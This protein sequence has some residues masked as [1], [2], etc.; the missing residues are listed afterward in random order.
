MVQGSSKPLSEDGTEGRQWPPPA[1]PA[2]DPLQ[3]H[4]RRDG[5]V[6]RLRSRR[7]AQVLIEE[8][9]PAAFGISAT[10]MAWAVLVVGIVIAVVG[11]VQAMRTAGEEPAAAAALDTPA[12]SQQI[13][14]LKIDLDRERAEKQDLLQ[15]LAA[16]QAEAAPAPEA[17]AVA[18]APG[19][20]AAAPKSDVTVA[21]EGEAGD[22]AAP[23]LP[24]AGTEASVA[25]PQPQAPAAQGPAPEPALPAPMA[26]SVELLK[27]TV[28]AVA[29]FDTA[30]AAAASSFGVHLASFADRVMAERGWV[31]LQRNHPAALGDLSPRIQDAK[32]EFR[33][34]D[35]PAAGRALSDAGARRRALQEHPLAGG[36]LQGAGIPRQRVDGGAVAPMKALLL[37]FPAPYGLRSPAGGLVQR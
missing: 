25:A 18:Q 16:A 13:E 21:A 20:P 28:P 32:D 5:H 4:Q 37:T 7:P 23:A 14:Q 19:V 3:H 11:A 2:F 27:P 26:P 17:P 30:E 8:T 31:L 33:Q 9:K 35:I 24:D 29:D 10:V 12:L 22:A 36:V 1:R 6:S 15:K 34:S